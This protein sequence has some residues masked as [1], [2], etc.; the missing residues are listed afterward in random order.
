MPSSSTG[1]LAVLLAAA[2]L[3]VA[4]CGAELGSTPKPSPTA[5]PDIA[6]P[7]TTASAP[8]SVAPVPTATSAPSATASASPP[9][10]AI[11]HA[12]A[13]AEVECTATGTTVTTDLVAAQRD[14]VHFHVRN[15]SGAN[16]AFQ[17][18][19]VGGDNTPASVG[20]L[21][22]PLQLG[23]A[24]IWC[25][26]SDTPTDA[27]WVTVTVVDPKGVFVP[28]TLTC[29]TVSH[30]SIDYGADAKGKKGDPVAIARSTITGLRPGD[31]VERAGYPAAEERKVRVVHDGQIAAVGT[32][33]S[34]QHGGWLLGSVDEC[35]GSTIRW[36]G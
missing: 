21:V 28:D 9:A 30:Q 29:G 3:V 16:P 6:T 22:F 24:R 10:T 36:G 27:D 5:A 4:G 2:G 13:A 14:G 33:F 25:G 17:I 23:P 7:S 1:R 34:D 20:T 19:G 32:Y 11:A 26:P 31:T 15:T 8:P 35:A 18:D 12:P